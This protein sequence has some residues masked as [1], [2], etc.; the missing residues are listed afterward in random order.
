[1][2]FDIIISRYRDG[3]LAPLPPWVIDALFQPFVIYDD[4]AFIRVRYPGNDGGADIWG[5]KKPEIL[6]LMFNHAGGPQFFDA[7]YHLLKETKSVIYWPMGRPVVADMR[8]P[9]TWLP[10]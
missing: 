8:L 7:L 3:A 5:T 1:M 2:S 10:I 9:P 6:S 4:E